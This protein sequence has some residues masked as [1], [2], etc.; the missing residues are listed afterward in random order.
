MRGHG[1]RLR[2]HQ[3]ADYSAAIA[4][5][6]LLDGVDPDRIVLW[7]TSYSGGHI[8]PAAVRD[9]R[10]AAIVSM[11]P[12]MDGLA[13]LRSLAAHAPRTLARLV[14]HGLRDGA[15]AL[16]RLTPHH[17]PIVGLPGSAA[18]ITTPGALAGYTELAGPTWRNEVCARTALEVALNRP[19]RL[20]SRLTCPVLVQ[21]GEN[22][23]VAPPAA[24]R[25]AAA[26]AGRHAELLTYPVDHFDV[27]AGPWQ[28]QALADQLEFL[29]RQAAPARGT[30]RKD[31]RVMVT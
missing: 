15:R 28:R 4:A 8:V 20:A 5:A 21:V 1:A 22:D 12:A 31:G 9:G 14:L 10:I 29:S 30:S 17:I 25:R 11:T 27:Y 2:R 26:R 23:S 7:G 16:I 19:G 6:R 13:V 3:R 18:I 24:A